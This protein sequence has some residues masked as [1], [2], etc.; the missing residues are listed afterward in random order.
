MICHICNQDMIFSTHIYKCAK[1]HNLNITKQENRYNLLIYNYNFKELKSKKQL[2]KFYNISSLPDFTKKFG[3]NYPNT[4]FLLDYYKIPKRTMS[5]SCTKIAEKKRKQTCLQKYGATNVLAKNTVFYEKRN[6]TVKEKYGVNNV[7]QLKDIIEKCNTKE[8]HRKTAIG[9]KKW[10]YNLT[11]DEKEKFLHNSIHSDTAKENTQKRPGY[12]VSKLEHKICEFLD[13]LNITYTRQF[14]L[15]KPKEVQGKY[16][17]KNY[18]YDIYLNDYN[19]IIEV[20][21]DYWHANPTKYNANDIILY[22]YGAKTAQDIWDRDNIKNNYAINKGYNL[23]II[24]ENEIREKQ[25]I[26]KSDEDIKTMI[27]NKINNYKPLN[28]L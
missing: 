20:N 25:M 1:N 26:M 15:K 22:I 12:I 7:F 16:N 18:F 11:Q 3:I 23:I 6:N 9:W 10:Y 27:L 2:E 17:N 24:W 19:L 5:E 8:A 13:L 14:K 28:N 4:Y 21:G